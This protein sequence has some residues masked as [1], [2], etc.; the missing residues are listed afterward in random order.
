MGRAVLEKA[1]PVNADTKR[2]LGVG[3][4]DLA[5]KTATHRLV[6]TKTFPVKPEPVDVPED[7]V[8][9]INDPWAWIVEELKKAV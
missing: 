3:A 7:V 1:V 4:G 8:M 6:V 2:L 5:E 9:C